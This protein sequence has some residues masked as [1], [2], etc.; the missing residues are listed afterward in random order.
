MPDYSEDYY[1]GYEDA[2]E[3]VLLVI[4]EMQNSYPFM[5]FDVA[6]LEELAQRIV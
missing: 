5:D 1:L 3:M 4:Q 6:T 2:R